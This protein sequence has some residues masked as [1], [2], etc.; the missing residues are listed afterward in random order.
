[1]TKILISVLVSLRLKNPDI[2]ISMIS[3]WFGVNV[4]VL[5]TGNGITSGISG[6]WLISVSVWIL[7]ISIWYRYWY[8]FWVSVS[9][10]GIDNNLGYRYQNRYGSSAGYRYQ[11]QGISGTLLVLDLFNTW[12]LFVHNLF[13]NCSFIFNCTSMTCSQLL[14]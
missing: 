7:G 9:G 11:Y 1:M 5:I 13:R 4:K 14:P 2:G 10:I 12:S 8:E 3:V 6:K